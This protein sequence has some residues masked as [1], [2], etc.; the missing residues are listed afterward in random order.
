MGTHG[1]FF[2]AA[3]DGATAAFHEKR[4]LPAPTRA[5]RRLSGCAPGCSAV[6]VAR[7]VSSTPTAP[8]L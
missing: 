4:A 6:A 3:L 5:A 2:S 7:T 1:A 8:I